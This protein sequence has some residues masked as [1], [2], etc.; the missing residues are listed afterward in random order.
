MSTVLLIWK[1][2]LAKIPVRASSAGTS[3]GNAAGE[4]PCARADA[5]AVPVGGH[6]DVA[7]LPE[8][9][10]AKGLAVELYGTLAP[11]RIQHSRHRPGKILADL[12]LMLAVGE[13]CLA[14]VATLR[15]EPEV[16][17]RWV[18]RHEGDA[19]GAG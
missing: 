1:K 2:G 16:H 7:L 14:D 6:A 19:P 17:D 4:F 3:R 15:A 10:R 8:T 18:E 13:D 11:R 5:T 12:A 9:F